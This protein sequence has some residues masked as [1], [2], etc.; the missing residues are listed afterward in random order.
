M[1]TLK[2]VFV[3]TAG[4]NYVY[5][6]RQVC[7]DHRVVAI[8]RAFGIVFVKYPVVVDLPVRFV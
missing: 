3:K 1:A 4:L 5:V 2:V 6:K 8:V 7:V